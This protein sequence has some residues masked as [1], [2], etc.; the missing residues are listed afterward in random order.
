MPF[1]PNGIVSLLTDFGLSDGYVAQMKA[2]MLGIS[3]SLRFVDI[4]HD[5]PA[6]DVAQGAFLLEEAARWFP[7][8]TVHLAVVDPGVGSSRSALAITAGDHVFIGPDNGLLPPAAGTLSP[9]PR[10][11]VLEGVTPPG[12]TV[13]ATFHG[14]DLFAPAA[15]EVACGLRAPEAFGPLIR[16]TPAPRRPTKTPDTGRVLHIDHFG[17]LITSFPAASLDGVDALEI[18]GHV[19]PTRVDCYAEAPAGTP[20]FLVGSSGRVEVSVVNGSA[21]DRLGISPGAEVLLRRS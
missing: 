15:A 14:R 7:V 17:N 16:P 21:A 8:G 11:R 10:A 5:V 2:V 1:R 19:V 13:S 9:D 3:P 12:G 6:G 4:T 18:R 20:V